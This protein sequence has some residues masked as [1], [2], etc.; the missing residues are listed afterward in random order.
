MVSTICCVHTILR[1]GSLSFKMALPGAYHPL[2]VRSAVF[3]VLSEVFEEVGAHH[4]LEGIFA[5]GEGM[6][7]VVPG[8]LPWF[9]AYQQHPHV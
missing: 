8:G 4:W 6:A 3:G 2:V 9:A 1:D 5:G 7:Q